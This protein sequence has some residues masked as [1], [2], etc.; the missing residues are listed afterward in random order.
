MERHRQQHGDDRTKASAARAPRNLREKDPV[1]KLINRQRE[2]QARNALSHDRL[3]GGSNLGG[4]TESDME[5][6]AL[7]GNFGPTTSGR[8]G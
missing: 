2:A 4:D 3:F 8:M 6:A 5:F 7:S 1:T